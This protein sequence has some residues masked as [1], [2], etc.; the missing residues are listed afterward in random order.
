MH[1]V[2]VAAAVALAIL[3]L[4][5][6]GL[7]KVGHRGELGKDG[8]LGVPPLVQVVDSPCGHVF[9]CKADVHVS[10][11]MVSDVVANHHFV[12]FAILARHLDVEV[13]VEEIV[14]LLQ[15]LGVEGAGGIVGRVQV[16]VWEEGGG[17]EGR[18][19][20]LA[21][22]LFPVSAC[23]DLEVEGAVDLVLFCPVDGCQMVGHACSLVDLAGQ[24]EGVEISARD[25]QAT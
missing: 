16:D 22:A 6:A 9:A 3:V 14:V 17:G 13:L 11:Q 15:L 24:S 12:D 7:A 19:D 5:T 21:A 25:A 8:P 20:V 23:A 2:A 1:K 10:D 18:L 4:P